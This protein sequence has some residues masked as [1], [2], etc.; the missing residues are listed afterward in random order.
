VPCLIDPDGLFNGDRF[1]QVSDAARFAWPY[2]WLAS[3]SFGRLELN[4][5][6]IVGRAFG[7]FKT[8]PSEEQFWNWVKEFQQAHL[9]FVYTAAGKLWG[10]WDCSEKYLPEYK[11][12][13]DRQSP[14]PPHDSFIAWKE[15]YIS[16]KQSRTAAKPIAPNDSKKSPEKSADHVEKFSTGI[17]V[18]VGEGKY[19]CPTDVGR[20]GTPTTAAKKATE[21]WTRD[22]AFMEFF[23]QNFWQEWPRKEQKKTAIKVLWKLGQ[24]RGLPFLRETVLVAVRKQKYSG[25]RLNPTGGASYIPMPATWLNAEEWENEPDTLAAS[26]AIADD[27]P[28][29]R[30]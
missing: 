6:R 5:H 30:A 24:Q 3:N 4:Y 16:E 25:G 10:Q 20:V 28:E 2:L 12:A 27:Y 29:L 23:N 18:G 1:E 11:T 8:I 17:G 26:S 21:P 14:A 9:L 13:R 22:A 7:R 19:S 15:E